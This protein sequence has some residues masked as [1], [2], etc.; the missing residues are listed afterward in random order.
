[1]LEIFDKYEK[2]GVY[3]GTNVQ[4]D[5]LLR[6]WAVHHAGRLPQYKKLIEELFSKKLI[7]VVIAT[8]TLGAGI[9][10][11]ARSVVMTNTAYKKYNPKTEEIEYTPLSANEFHQM[12]GRAGRRG[13][14]KVGHVILYNLHTPIDRF[15]KDEDKDKNG[16][17]DE[18]W[19]AYQLMDSDADNLRSTFRPQ[20]P[21]LAQY[22]LNNTT[23]NNLYNLIKQSFRYYCSKDK[24]KA[25]KQMFKKFENFTQILI[26]QKC[27]FKNHRKE[28]TLTPKGEILMQAQGMNPLMLTELLYEEELKNITPAQLCQ[29]AA[30]IQGSEEQAEN[31]AQENLINSKITQLALQGEADISATEFETTKAKFKKHEEKIIKALKE[32]NIHHT[33][34]RVT[35]SFS[36]LVGY[37]FASYNELNDN[38]I[39]NFEKIIDSAN[40]AQSSDNEANKEYERKATEGNVYK[41]ITGS[42]STLKQIIRICD[43]AIGS[44]DKYPNTNYWENLKET[45]QE[46]IKLLDKEPI[47]N[48]PDYAN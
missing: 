26:K 24:Q 28:M 46:A 22:Y 25:E 21:M 27:L 48:N 15:R 9:N 1:M 17:I 14:D 23:P 16:K 42:I 29:L 39:A 2:N 33:D 45:A 3:L 13:I 30:H 34:I 6:G 4:K 47:N 37:L 5:M 41:I 43:F 31:E 8:S 35:D 12:A 32:S 11:P 44:E 36:G 20:A 10:M 18:L 38:S 40:I 19:L 7:K